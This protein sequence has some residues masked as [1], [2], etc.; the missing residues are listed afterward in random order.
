MSDCSPEGFMCLPRHFNIALSCHMWAKNTNKGI[1][2]FFKARTD[3]TLRRE[4]LGERRRIPLLFMAVSA[5]L[6][7]WRW[8]KMF[9]DKA[10]ETWKGKKIINVHRK[11][12]TPHNNQ[13]AVM[14]SFKSA[15]VLALTKSAHRGRV[16]T[17]YHQ[18]FC[19]LAFS[20]THWALPCIRGGWQPR[21]FHLR[22]RHRTWNILYNVWIWIELDWSFLSVF[23][24]LCHRWFP[25]LSAPVS[26]F[27]I[28]RLS[29]SLSLS[30]ACCRSSRL[31]TS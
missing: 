22:I 30:V 27:T 13:Q 7:S 16:Q 17:K 3:A 5:F 11:K 1:S 10:T 26:C 9:T 15:P 20:I 29:L 14:L 12:K 18:R 6:S 24:I 21:G 4:R 19:Y 2:T 25:A 28:N 31:S 23:A 8:L